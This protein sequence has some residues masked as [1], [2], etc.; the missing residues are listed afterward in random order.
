MIS[1]TL[2][3]LSKKIT[4]MG[5]CMPMVCT[6]LLGTSHKASSGPSFFRR[7]SPT[8]RVKKL[9]AFRTVVA[10]QVFLVKFSAGILLS[11]WKAR[12]QLHEVYGQ[13]RKNHQEQRGQDEK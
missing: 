3:V 4:S 1:I 13:R 6:P 2:L 9:S 5:K 10:N 12:K 11:P 8:R 7:S